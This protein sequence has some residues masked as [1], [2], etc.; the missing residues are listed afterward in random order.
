MG[1]WVL[2]GFWVGTRVS[3]A[4]HFP[5]ADFSRGELVCWLLRLS[6]SWPSLTETR[7]VSVCPRTLAP[8][9]RLPEILTAKAEEFE[10]FMT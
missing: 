3:T 10:A 2:M 4:K 9:P 6:L 8:C 7:R 5:P 1:A